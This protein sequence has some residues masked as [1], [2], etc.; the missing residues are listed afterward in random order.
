MNKVKEIGFQRQQFYFNLGRVVISIFEAL[1]I[2]LSQVSRISSVYFEL[3]QKLTLRQG[4]E[5]QSV[6]G[7]WRKKHHGG[8][9]GSG[10]SWQGREGPNKGG[11]IK[12]I[13]T[14]GDWKFGSQFQLYTS[15]NPTSEYPTQRSEGG[16]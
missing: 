14:V 5:Y 12:P 3:L 16:D 10:E 15:E 9:G 4:F 8:K 11:I 1:Q 6:P 2:W 13:I 7:K